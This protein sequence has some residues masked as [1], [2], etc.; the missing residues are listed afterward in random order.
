MTI[1]FNWAWKER[2]LIWITCPAS[3]NQVGGRLVPVALSVT[4][5]ETNGAGSF[6]VTVMDLMRC[7]TARKARTAWGCCC[8]TI[9][10]ST[11]KNVES[12]TE[13]YDARTRSSCGGGGRS[14]HD[15]SDGTKWVARER[16]WSCA[17]QVNQGSADRLYQFCRGDICIC[18]ARG[19]AAAVSCLGHFN[20][21]ETAGAMDASVSYSHATGSGVDR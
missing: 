5:R 21:V 13:F 6:S 1:V 19:V 15:S 14:S 12:A 11:S 20:D 18:S 17:G 16:A 7:A 8:N 3:S 9:S 4:P 2:A 10:S